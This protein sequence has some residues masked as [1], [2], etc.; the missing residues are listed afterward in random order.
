MHLTEVHASENRDSSLQELEQVLSTIHDEGLRNFGSP[1][2]LM[3]QMP[4]AIFLPYDGG[5][6]E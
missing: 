6:K 1:G 3:C 2:T 5:C 4:S